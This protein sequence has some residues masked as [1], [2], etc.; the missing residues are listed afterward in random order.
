[1]KGVQEQSGGSGAAGNHYMIRPRYP[2]GYSENLAPVRMFSA[3]V[4]KR[5]AASFPGGAMN[6]IWDL[7]FAIGIDIGII[8]LYL[9]ERNRGD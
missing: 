3:K 7:R 4:S 6:L 9:V 2:A 1:M 5:L 8:L